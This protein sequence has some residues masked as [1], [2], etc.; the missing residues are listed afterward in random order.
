VSGCL[1]VRSGGEALALAVADVEEVL[2]LGPPLP[3]PATARGVRGVVPVRGRLVPL[4]HLGALLRRRA[5]P[6]EAGTVGVAVRAAGRRLVL[7]VD[8]AVDLVPRPPEALP[9]GWGTAWA[10]QGI[11]HGGRL[12]PVVDLDAVAARLLA[13][14]ED[15]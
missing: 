3:A 10:T 14:G 11:R 9:A 5:A 15:G 13:G 6:D 2:E 4:A 7:E 12:V 8:E 1:I